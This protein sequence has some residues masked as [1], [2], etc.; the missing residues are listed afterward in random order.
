MFIVGQIRV[1][2]RYRGLARDELRYILDPKEVYGED[3]PPRDVPR[4][5]GE[6]NQAVWGVQDETTRFGGVG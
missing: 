5:E 2:G 1:T 4:A 6:R 3:F